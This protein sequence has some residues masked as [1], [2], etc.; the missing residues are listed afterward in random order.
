MLKLTMKL[1]INTQQ[2]A[3]H[4]YKKQENQL[5]ITQKMMLIMVMDLQEEYEIN[6]DSS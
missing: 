1:K 2:K 5:L 6:D 4:A 3:N